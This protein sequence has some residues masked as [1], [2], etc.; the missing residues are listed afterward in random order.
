MIGDP[1]FADEQPIL[2]AP[3]QEGVTDDQID[4]MMV[5]NPRRFFRP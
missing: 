1:A 2:P 5:V 4:E 3:R